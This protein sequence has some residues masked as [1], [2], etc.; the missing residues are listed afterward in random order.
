MHA[1]KRPKTSPYLTLTILGQIALALQLTSRLSISS[2]AAWSLGS[3]TRPLCHHLA[4]PCARR[5][6]YFQ[7]STLSDARWPAG[8]PSSPLA[9]S[10]HALP[11]YSHASGFS[12]RASR[13]RPACSRLPPFRASP[14]LTWDFHL[15]PILWRAV[16]AVWAGLESSGILNSCSSK[17]PTRDVVRVLA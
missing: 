10:V 13:T 9:V 7:S 17:G 12:W 16:Q 1:A 3:G 11:T 4:G 5:R 8:G 6:L 2:R 14:S 15:P